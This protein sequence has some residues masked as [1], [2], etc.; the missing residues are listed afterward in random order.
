MSDPSLA[1]VECYSGHTYAGE[2]RALVWQGSRYRV[3]QVEERWRT[4]EGPGFR[5]RTEGGTTFD[6]SYHEQGDRWSIRPWPNAAGTPTQG[7]RTA[8]YNE[9]EEV[10]AKNA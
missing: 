1:Q 9:D 6:L 10:Q 7:A 5:V 3:V 2:P 4:P 8:N